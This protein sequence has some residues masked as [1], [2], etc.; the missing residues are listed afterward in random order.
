MNTLSL[1][2]VESLLAPISADQ[3]CGEDMSFSGEFDQIQEARREDD[4]SLD[5]GEWVTSLKEADW[6]LSASLAQQL[7]RERTKDL[8]LASWLTEALAKTNDISGMTSGYQIIDGL[9]SQYWEQMHPLAEDGDLE[10][11]IGNISW[12]ITRC[13]QLVRGF[14]L[15]RNK[16]L[17]YG[18]V[19]LEY[20]RAFQSALDRNQPQD[21]SDGAA[22]LTLQQIRE[23]QRNTPRSFY[24][25]SMAACVACRTAFDQMVEHIDAQLGM[26]GPSFAPLRSALETY[27]DTIERMARENGVIS[28]GNEEAR[29]DAFEDASANT[30]ASPPASS[31]SG[32]LRSREQALRQLR[33][34]AE[35]FRQTEPH[36]PVAYLADKAASW[37]EMPLHVWLKAVLK[38]EGSLARFEDLLGFDSSS[39]DE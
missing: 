6:K 1:L 35:F 36:S 4:P 34:V 24:Q 19:D 26:E 15:V 3:P 14:P 28:S 13:V 25:E 32:P 5:Q 12:L 17:R 29:D 11:R 38:E 30:E 16:T 20:A 27:A 8:R 9:V 7:L 37:G 2:S 31:A 10:Q 23:A 22:R 39:S 33:Q 21:D 18:L